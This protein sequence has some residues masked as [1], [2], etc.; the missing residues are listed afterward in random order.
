MSFKNPAE[1]QIS[2]AFSL[3]L[4]DDLLVQLDSEAK[5]RGVTKPSLVRDILEQALRKQGPARAL[6][7]YDVTR[8]LPGTFKGLPKDLVSDPNTWSVLGAVALARNTDRTL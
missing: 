1:Q 2:H 7:C 8:D 5:A 3:K 6:S 4:P